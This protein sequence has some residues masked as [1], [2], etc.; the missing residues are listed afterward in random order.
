MF[1]ATNIATEDQIFK[2]CEE[3]QSYIESHY[4]ADNGHAVTDRAQTLEAYMALSGKML[5]D[6]KYR[7]NQAITSDFINAYKN[8]S[9]MAPTVQ[10]RYLDSICKDYQYLVD[11]CERINR[12]CTHQIDMCRSILSTLREEMKQVNYGAK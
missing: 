1:K 9:N 3:I 7:L 2:S 11:W 10:K 6:A 12:T 8:V 5:A 4:E